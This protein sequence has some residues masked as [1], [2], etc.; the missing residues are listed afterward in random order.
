MNKLFLWLVSFLDPVWRK[1]DADPKAIKLI[2]AA[3]LKMD[4]RS[5]FA[6]GKRKQQK[7]GM[8]YMTYFFIGLMGL[9]LVYLFQL[10]ENPATAVG[11]G[12]SVWVCYIGLMLIT[13]MSENLFDQRDLYVLL[14]RPI[15]DYTLSISRILHITVFSGKFALCLG[16]PSFVYLGIVEGPWPAI[17][18][19]L[20][21]IV[22]IV[23]IMTGTLVFYLL[24]LRKVP[25]NRVKKIV[26]YF[27]ILATF[28]F[29]TMYQLPS[30]LGDVNDLQNLKVVDSPL[31]FSFP[32][33]W[34]GGL[35]KVMTTTSVGWMGFAQAA[36]ALIAAG[37]GGWFY[38][39][40]STGY[41]DRLLALRHAGSV[42][43]GETV[44][45]S[46]T[47]SGKSPVRDRLAAW[48]TR[49]NQERVS[50]K[51]HWNVMVR[52]M[53]FKQRTYPALVYLPVILG[54]TIFKDA[55]TGEE[56][57]SVGP[58][59]IL[60]L[61]Y[62]LMWIVI[63]PLG[64]TKISESYRAAWIFDATPNAYP[65]RIMYGQ[66]LAVLG[67]FYL[68][69]AVLVYTAVLAFQGLDFIPDILL[70]SGS[71]LLFSFIYSHVDK[72]HPFSR[73]KDDSKFSNFGP[74]LMI[75]FLGGIL[76]VGHYGL[77]LLPYAVPVAAGVVWLVL[78]G[79]VVLL[80]R[81]S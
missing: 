7:K 69:L 18:Y 29:I 48:F 59:T 15:N 26:G 1:F 36:L 78:I 37:F 71:T 56:A 30:L 81:K 73:S 53:T 65:S 43:G 45:S 16:L 40:Q 54:V 41:A 5:G 8:E 67:M 21:S 42:D 62:F 19:F 75:S 79:W 11:L 72:G 51:Y 50:F 4:D 49:P 38:L 39:R 3:K 80:R 58:G 57:L 2:L 34:L 22:A 13:E 35:F 66:L 28:V 63:I 33:L 24:L 31:G 10:S 20:V 77:R 12:F 9:F 55:I 27:Q 52:D 32:G 64:Q 61:L 23:V 14:S 60:T 6:M 74:F 44:S 17:A 25:A 76:G 68:P 46:N 47:S 70:A